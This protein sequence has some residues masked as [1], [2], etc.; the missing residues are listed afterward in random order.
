MVIYQESLHDARSTKYKIL[1]VMSLHE[2]GVHG[3][4]VLNKW[5]SHICVREDLIKKRSCLLILCSIA[6]AV[7]AANLNHLLLA[8]QYTLFEIFPPTLPMVTLQ[9]VA[10]TNILFP[11]ADSILSLLAIHS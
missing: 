4:N 5:V 1:L 9:T 11:T 3:D 8:Q 6:S 2:T 10:L 7:L